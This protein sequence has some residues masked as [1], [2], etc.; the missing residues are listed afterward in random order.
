MKVTINDIAN[1][2][3]V[4]ATTVSRALNYDETLSIS[5]DTRKRIFEVAE[6]LKY[7][8]PTR[9][10]RKKKYNIGLYCSYSY[11]EELTDTYYLSIRIAIENKIRDDKLNIHRIE[12]IDDFKNLNNIDGIIALGTFDAI[13]L[14]QMEKCDKPIVFVDFRDTSEI[15]DSVIIDY[16]SGVKKAMDHLFELGHEKIAFIGGCDY[17]SFGIE[18]CD[19]RKLSYANTMKEKNLFNEKYK[20]IG[21]FNPD[22]G[23]KLTK[24]LLQED[25]IPTAILVAND[26]IAIGSYKAI[27][28]EGLKIPEDISIIG[29]N[30][31][32]TSAYMYPPLTT[33]RL[34][35]DYMGITAV[36][37]LIDK[38][39]TERELCKTIII[40]TK[41][42]KRESCSSVAV[43]LEIAQ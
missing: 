2:V 11:E 36:D 18:M 3:G 12:T 37:T 26:S 6:K 29:F 34:H 31:I 9:K 14:S 22:S 10:K 19:E 27:L 41:L 16:K 40:P 39:T 8:A 13:K 25:D 5:D 42:I 7:E 24:E 28:E 15:Y 23:F 33:I 43:K 4:S 20:K 30:D 17:N 32:S 38:L 35:T 1:E 21:K